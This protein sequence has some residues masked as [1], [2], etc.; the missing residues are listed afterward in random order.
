MVSLS[1]NA[2]AYLKRA[3]VG[4]ER[5]ENACFRLSLGVKGPDLAL[6]EVRP[7]DRKV[8]YEG[9]VVLTVEPRLESAIGDQTLDY[10]TEKERLVLVG[11]AES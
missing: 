4:V 1:K 6:D 3:L 8:E 5:P 2:G 10:D 7:G 9:D 11:A